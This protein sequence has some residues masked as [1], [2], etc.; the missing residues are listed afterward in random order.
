MTAVIELQD[1]RLRLN[2][3]AG[4]FYDVIVDGLNV[5]PNHGDAG[6]VHYWKWSAA[7][8][9]AYHVT[10]ERWTRYGQ[11]AAGLIKRFGR[12]PSGDGLVQRG[13]AR[14]DVPLRKP[15]DRSCLLTNCA[16]G[17]LP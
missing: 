3:P 1:D 7:Q 12:S 2:F 16:I 9:A 5:G 11:H 6:R 4:P 15:G 13:L 14:L 10:D 17:T 8:I